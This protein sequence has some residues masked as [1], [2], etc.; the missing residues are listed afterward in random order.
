MHIEALQL[1]GRIIMENGGETYRVE[2][3]ITH[4]ATAMGMSEIESFAVPSGVFFSYLSPDGKH[5]SVVTRVHR[6]GTN[7]CRVNEVNAVS[8]RLEAG[9]LDVAGAL[10]ELKRIDQTKSRLTGWMVVTATGISCA[11]WGGL[12][13]GSWLDALICLVIGSLGQ[14]VNFL[15]ERSRLGTQFALLLSSFVVTLLPMVFCALSGMGETDPI[16]AG[17]LMP[18]VPGLAMTN[19][20]RD[21]MRGDILSGVAHG[22][23]AVLT[24]V[25]LALG[26]IAAAMTAQ[27]VIGRMM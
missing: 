1:A 22:F 8:R 17:A 16:I 11:G 24:A 10:A 20:V 26:A 7:L 5:E 14:T 23:T 4:M 3:T 6:Q 21:T 15:V 2:E 13:G 9:E 25:L 18:F 19:A 27:L 12:F